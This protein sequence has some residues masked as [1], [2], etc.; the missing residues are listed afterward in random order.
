MHAYTAPSGPVAS[1]RL[2]G[3]RRVHALLWSL[4]AVATLGLLLSLTLVLQNAVRQAGLRHAATAAQ[5]GALWRC[6]TVP[7]RDARE[8]CRR[9]AEATTPPTAN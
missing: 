8:H 9:V 7:G 3:A 2:G 6:N 5:A 4:A 1:A